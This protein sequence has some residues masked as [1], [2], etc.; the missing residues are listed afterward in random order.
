VAQDNPFDVL[1]LDPRM[2]AR[3]LT[4]AL[5]QRA[6]RAMPEERQR[7]Q[8][9]WRQLTLKETDRIKWALLAHPRTRSAALTGGAL[10]GQGQIE[11]LAAKV[12]PFVSRAKLGPLTVAAQDLIVLP[13]LDDPRA[14]PVK[15]P[16]P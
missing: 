16:K 12:P 6:E 14:L 15:P 2:N 5:R 4:E 9:L 7:L 11:A 10:S 13:A 1:G 3:Q 8:G